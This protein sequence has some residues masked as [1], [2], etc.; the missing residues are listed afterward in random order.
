[1]VGELSDVGQERTE[2]GDAVVGQDGHVV[3]VRV[4]LEDKNMYK[5]KILF[6]HTTDD[7]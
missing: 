1:V 7:K 2:E 3:A 6:A 4:R 5:W